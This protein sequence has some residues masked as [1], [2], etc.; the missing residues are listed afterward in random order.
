MKSRHMLELEKK[1]IKR[2]YF[3]AALAVAVKNKR[4][5]KAN[6]NNNIIYKSKS[7]KKNCGERGVKVIKRKKRKEKGRQNKSKSNNNK[8]VKRR[9]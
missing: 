1:K 8:A 3:E 2:Y 4:V 6:N 7:G 9:S 5:G